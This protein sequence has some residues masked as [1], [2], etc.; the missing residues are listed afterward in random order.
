MTRRDGRRR[1]VGLAVASILMFASP[2]RALLGDVESVAGLDGS[3]RTIIGVLDNYS[4]ELL[5]DGDDSDVISQSVL[6]LTLAGKPRPWLRYELHGLQTFDAASTPGEPGDAVLG[7]G[8]IGAIAGVS[9]G[10][11]RYQALDLQTRWHDDSDLVARAS[12]DRA[13]ATLRLGRIDLTVGRQAITFGKAYFW[14]ILDVFLPFDPEQFDRDYKPGV[15][16]LRLDVALGAFTGI[17]LVAVAGPDVP[18]VVITREDDDFWEATWFGSAVLGRVFTNLAGWDF[19]LQGGKVYGGYQVG[20]GAVGEIGPMELRVEVV[21]HFADDSPPLIP[22]ALS[23]PTSP[24]RGDL[25][26]NSTSLVVGTGHRFDNSLTVELEYFY[27]GAGD[28][29]DLLASAL[30]ASAGGLLNWS[31]NLVGLALS[32][33][34]SPIVVGTLG[35][36]V[37]LDDGSTQIQPGI[38]WAAADELE[39]LAGIILNTGDRPD[40]ALESEFGTLPHLFYSEI[41]YYF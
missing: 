4:S 19:A 26:E 38:K 7:G 35:S 23:P 2:C 40:P 10:R 27:N 34:I 31:E 29:D 39:V 25:V 3:I 15:D 32:Y 14:S 5:F 8:G 17:N 41:K 11:V 12:L 33:E 9:S 24:E 30:R 13:N 36:I 21:K 6:R 22:S 1:T 16:A 20:G 28:A 18:A 37:S